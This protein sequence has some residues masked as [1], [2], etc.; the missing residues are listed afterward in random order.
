[1]ADATF[2]ISRYDAGLVA[3]PFD[4]AIDDIFFASSQTQTFATDEERVHFRHRW[5]GR[6]L[7]NFSDCAFVASMGDEIVGYVAGASV[8]PASHPLF[9]DID[10]FKAFAD[11]TPTFPAH[12]HVNVDARYRSLGIGAALVE[13]FAQRVRDKGAPG[14]HVVTAKGAR[15]VDFYLRTGFALIRATTLDKRELAFLGRSDPAK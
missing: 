5:L 4:A 12:L 13:A 14:L 10:Y 9:N 2:T 7:V 11:L 15:N 6:Y 8:D 3:R 1:M